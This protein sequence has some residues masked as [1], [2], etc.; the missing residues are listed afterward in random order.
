M[1]YEKLILIAVGFVVVVL[2]GS[3]MIM[4]NANPWDTKEDS[5]TGDGATGDASGGDGGGGD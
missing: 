1:T 3:W 2:F 4:A 5:D